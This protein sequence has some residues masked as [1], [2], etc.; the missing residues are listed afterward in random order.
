MLSSVSQ[1]PFRFSQGVGMFLGPGLLLAILATPAPEAISEEG[2][3]V[4]AVAALMLSWWI[5]E[6][7]PIPVTALTP[8]VTFPL[9][10]VMPIKQVTASYGHP[11]VFLFL[12]GFVIALAMQKWQLH[13][14]IALYIVRLT[15]TRA[16]G[17]LAGFMIATAFLSMWVSNTATTVMMLPIVLSV[18][19][20]LED[21]NPLKHAKLATALLLGVAFAAN[22]GGTATIIGTPP[23]AI[24][25]GFVFDQYGLEITFLSWF[26]VGMPFML[27]MLFLTWIL[28][29]FLFGLKS[30]GEIEGSEEV[31]AHKWELLGSPSK[32]EKITAAIFVSTAALWMGK[33]LLPFSLTD[34]TIAMIGALAFFFV[35]V[36]LK[37]S[38]FLLNWEDSKQLPWGILLL[39]GGGLNLAG[40]MSI[41]GLVGLVG[42]NIAFFQQYGFFVLALVVVFVVMF[43]TEG[44]SNLA[45]IAVMLPVISAVSLQFEVN[46]LVLTVAATL[47]SS[48]AFMLPMATP[49][50][51]IVFSSGH[52][53]IIDMM[54]VGVWVNV[55]SISVIMVLVFTLVPMVFDQ[56]LSMFI[57]AR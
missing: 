48:C 24:L 39:F 31:I 38:D 55:L 43:M 30:F 41:S 21:K 15:S 40:A 19:D 20:L 10:D 29:V 16:T 23:N 44:M 28:L 46:P 5:S 3:K 50:N 45:L 37:K 14:R 13:L 35:P 4:I 53:R 49:P 6:A 42:E 8:I 2:W 17:I 12:G 47:A 27:V 33:S 25:A 1:K 56:P 57:G 32:Q 34:T 22:I 7:V 18:L 36:N 51:A 52:L 9:L 54:K 11:I 26:V